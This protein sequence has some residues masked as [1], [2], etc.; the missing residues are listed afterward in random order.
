MIGFECA[1]TS[2]AREVEPSNLEILDRHFQ[3][4]FNAVLVCAFEGLHGAKERQNLF[5]GAEGHSAV[6]TQGRKALLQ[7]FIR[8]D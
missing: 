4:M 7:R 2:S 6:Y 5:N 3:Q 1:L 8:P